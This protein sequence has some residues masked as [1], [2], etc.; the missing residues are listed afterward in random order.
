[1][2]QATNHWCNPSRLR[3][4]ST[5]PEQR[6]PRS[7]FSERIPSWTKPRSRDTLEIRKCALITR[8][9]DRFTWWTAHTCRSRY[10][11]SLDYAMPVASSLPTEKWQR[12]S[13][14]LEI[15]RCVCSSPLRSVRV[16]PTHTDLIV[17]HCALLPELVAPHLGLCELC[18]FLAPDWKNSSAVGLPELARRS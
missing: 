14:L 18:G 3:Q 10:L 15:R 6:V 5:P 1:M 17:P 13:E 7:H 11:H 16:Q 4:C 12:L 2:G 9:F 8:R